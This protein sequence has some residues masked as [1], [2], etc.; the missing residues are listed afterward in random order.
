MVLRKLMAFCSFY[1][2]SKHFIQDFDTD[3]EAMCK[4]RYQC[5]ENSHIVTFHIGKKNITLFYQS[6]HESVLSFPLVSMYGVLFLKDRNKLMQIVK[7]S[8][9][10]TVESQLSLCM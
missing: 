4:K 8:G 5:S 10:L 9:K 6:F 7:W 3:F 2:H 1:T